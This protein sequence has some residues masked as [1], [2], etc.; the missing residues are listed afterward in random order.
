MFDVYFCPR[1]VQRL[2][3]SPD[4][5]TIQS[6]LTYLHE[7]GH[8]RLTIQEYVHAVEVFLRSRRRRRE[9]LASV[10]EAVVRVFACR[11]RSQQCPRASVHAALRHLL[12]HLKHEGVTIPRSSAANPAMERIVA[13]YDAYLRDAGGLAPA[14]RLYRR[15]YARE[16]IQSV[17][18]E[19]PVRWERIR[20]T[21]VRS[22]IAGYSQDGHFSAAQVAAGS[23]RSFLRWLRLQGH[24]GIQLIAA[25][26]RCPRWRLAGLPTAMTDKQLRTFL[27]TFPRS[28]PS[29]RRNY[30]MAVCMT[31]L[32][33]RVGEIAALTLADLDESAGTLRLTAGKSRRDRVL[34]MPRKVR[35]AI[36]R[37][38]RDRPRTSD[39]HL[40]VRYRVPIGGGVSRELIRGVVRL[41]YAQVAGCEKWTG[42]HVLRHTAAS[43]L[44][45]AGADIK[46][47][48]DILGHLSIDTTAI[49][50][51][52]D[53]D[54]LAKVALPWP[55]A[56]TTK[57]VQL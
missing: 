36:I 51:K 30:A 44:H 46:R 26:P 42:T 45:R 15:R 20:S 14:T 7:R 27:K 48:A 13:Q 33:L 53:L 17:F 23:L 37:Y 38:R 54:R 6:F 50:T 57:E 41:A 8:A 49:Y 55:A 47:V 5:A 34:P 31:D 35:Q 28:T 4:A 1:V 18:G 10:D 52:I 22:F 39:P 3:A 19:K 9:P 16:F 32:G 56:Q 21:H 11:R 29:G 2:K 40:F 12:R 24:T 25:V 43:R